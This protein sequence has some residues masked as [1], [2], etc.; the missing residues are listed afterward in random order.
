MTE[1]ANLQVQKP[2]PAEIEMVWRRGWSRLRCNMADV[3]FC[4][5]RRRGGK[6]VL[7]EAI[8]EKN[9]AAGNGVLDLTGASIGEGLGWLRS[10]WVEDGKKVVLLKG[11]NVDVKCSWE[12]KPWDRFELPDFEKYDIIIS[13]TPFYSSREEEVESV[14]RIVD[15]S[16]FR[17]GNVKM[18]YMLVREATKLFYSRKKQVMN[19][20][21][22]KNEALYFVS[23]IRHHGFLLGMETQKNTLIDPDIREQCDFIFF[24]PQGTAMLPR[25]YKWLYH[26]L[27]PTWLQTMDVAEFGVITN[28]GSVGVGVNEMPAWHK[29][30]KEDLIAQLG[31]QIDYGEVIEEGKY[32]GT[33]STVGDEEHA[34][35]IRLY[36]EGEGKGMQVIAKEL[37]RSPHTVMDQIQAHNSSIL[38]SGYC[39]ICDKVRSPHRSIRAVRKKKGV[40]PEQ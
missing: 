40:I 23:E 17:R 12:V 1:I 14:R 33:Y 38:S 29:Q 9:L 7:L 13:V 16:Y 26:F 36:V 22:L 28:T 24:K 15:K 34:E 20:I 5:G 10:G 2:R 27:E 11:K 31:I 8:G 4:L 39:F 6:S 21:E 32:R 18:V 3:Y 19:Q 35:L 37:S 25:D 30:E